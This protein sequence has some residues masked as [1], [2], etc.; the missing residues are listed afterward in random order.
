MTLYNLLS[1][2]SRAFRR[3]LFEF[4]KLFNTKLV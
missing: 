2:L 3:R 4:G 1:S